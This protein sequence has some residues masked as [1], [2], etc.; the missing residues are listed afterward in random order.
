MHTWGYRRPADTTL[1]RID[2]TFNNVFQEYKK[3]NEGEVAT[4][5]RLSHSS[6]HSV[7][8]NSPAHD[9]ENER[10]DKAMEHNLARL[11]AKRIQQ[12]R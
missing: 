6:G 2:T 5:G 4:W 3:A 9:M 1:T 7:Q 12:Y 10:Q 8:R 11:H